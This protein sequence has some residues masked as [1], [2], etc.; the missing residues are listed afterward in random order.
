[1]AELASVVLFSDHLDETIA[2]YRALG[3]PLEDE[4]HG[5]GVLHAAGEMGDV[6]F[7]VLAA[8]QTG[9]ETELAPRRLDLR[10]P[11]GALTGSGRRGGSGPWVPRSCV[12]HQQCEWGC[13]IVVS[14]P[15]GRAVELNQEGHC[16]ELTA[17]IAGSMKLT[18]DLHDIYNRGDDI[19][20]ALRDVIEEAVAKKAKLVEIIPGK[21]SG[22]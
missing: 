6:H 7:A 5:D 20:R 1:M 14:D 10:R 17:D 11:V 12:D 2:F 16:A 3:V 9:S 22:S 8:G 18:L 4:D 15:D 13:R 21:G 19:D